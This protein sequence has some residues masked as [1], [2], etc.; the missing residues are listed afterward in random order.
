MAHYYV[1]QYPVYIDL[2]RIRPTTHVIIARRLFMQKYDY[3]I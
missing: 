2:S 1:A 3:C